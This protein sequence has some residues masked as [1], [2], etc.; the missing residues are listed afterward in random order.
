MTGPSHYLT[1][2]GIGLAGAAVVMPEYGL[3]AAGFLLMGAVSGSRA[4][5]HL[6]GEFLNHRIIRHR[7]LTH[8]FPFWLIVLI[9]GI[10]ETTRTSLSWLLVGYSG[11]ALLHIFCDALT[12]MGVP[13]LT[14]WRRVSLRMVH[15]WAGELTVIVLAFL[16]AGL[17]WSQ[18]AHADP[19]QSNV[20]SAI[21]GKLN[22][23]PKDCRVP[24]ECGWWWGFDEK[25]AK[26]HK[27]KKKKHVIQ[28]QRK[29][30]KNL[31]ASSKTWTKECGFINPKGDFALQAKERDALRI[32][33][34]M[35]PNNQKSVIQFQ[36]Y[37]RWATN[38]SILFTQMWQ[39][40]MQQ[41]PSLNPRSESP[42]SR[43]GLVMASQIKNANARNV[44]RELKSLGAF[45]V[46]FSRSDCSY[47]HAMASTV[48]RLSHQTGLTIWDASLDNQC[49]SGF[50]HCRTANTTTRPAEVLHV[51]IVPSLF[52]YVPKS[53]SWI[54]ISTGI[55]SLDAVKTRTV[56]FFQ[57]VHNAAEHGLRKGVNGTAPVDFKNQ[58]QTRKLMLEEAK[59]HGLARGISIPS[60]N[61][62]N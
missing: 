41:I 47:C 34:V 39:Y 55:S 49:L 52:L 14:P 29:S 28:A 31:C 43:F 8:W 36:K 45:F 53:Q 11:A 21:A 1:A 42:I 30:H 33:A 25:I 46:Y 2:L 37:M 56:E 13:V 51:T 58:T 6:E 12:P 18:V 22:A 60:T 44:W 17:S 26:K 24:G 5:D 10:H 23:K 19:S 59:Q 54:R 48:K 62:S 16:S 38:E 57:A 61:N 15:G 50:K 35:H 27:K 32:N 4:P 40:N 3:P 20:P 9:L 7:T